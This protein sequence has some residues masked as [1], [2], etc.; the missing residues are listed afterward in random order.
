MINQ[1]ASAATDVKGAAVL[2]RWPRW[3]VTLI[4]FKTSVH[5][6]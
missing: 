1:T 5:G 2:G 4:L 6:G 3:F